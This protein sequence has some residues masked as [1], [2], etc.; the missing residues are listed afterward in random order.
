MIES[1]MS[2]S[3]TD[4]TEGHPLNMRLTFAVSVVVRGISKP[5]SKVDLDD[6]LVT[7]RLSLSSGVS[8]LGPKP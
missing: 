3:S 5:N 8:G 2:T 6:G 1:T 4:L 7:G